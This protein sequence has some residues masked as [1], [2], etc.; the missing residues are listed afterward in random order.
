M[1]DIASG[2]AEVS[3]IGIQRRGIE[4]TPFAQ[5][6]A[7]MDWAH[8]RPKEQ[9]WLAWTEVAETLAKPGPGR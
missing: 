8:G 3:V 7:Q 9:A 5:A 1:A 4:T 2:S 6:M